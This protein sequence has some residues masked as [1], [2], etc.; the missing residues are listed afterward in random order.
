MADIGITFPSVAIFNPLTY[1]GTIMA[2]KQSAEIAQ[3]YR[4]IQA[5]IDAGCPRHAVFSKSLGLCASV[6]NWAAKQFSHIVKNNI[7]DELDIQFI[8]AGLEDFFPFNNCDFYHE[9]AY[10]ALYNNPARLAWIKAHAIP[11]SDVTEQ[12]EG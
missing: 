11:A 12:S 7:C 4:E 8:D 2:I 1:Q 5:W 3:F 9:A 10:E 6:Y